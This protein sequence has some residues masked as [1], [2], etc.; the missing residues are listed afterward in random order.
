M[1]TK[2]ERVKYCMTCTNRKFSHH[3]GV[4][5]GL[6]NQV[7]TFSEECTDY[8]PDEKQLKLRKLRKREALDNA[9]K[10]LRNVRIAIFVIASLTIFYGFYEAFFMAGANVIFGVIDWFMG[11]VFI[12]LGIWSYSK[13]FLSFVIA[14]SI[15]VLI[16]VLFFIVEPVSIFKGIILKGVIIYT[17]IV[18]IQQ[19][20]KEKESL[21]PVDESLLD[22]S[23]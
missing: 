19:A 18:G 2:E 4:I 10:K 13:P 11:A 8:S 1:A 6:T 20:K 17:F 16:Q 21:K 5:C 3:E 23:F 7:A 9:R 15:Y 12:G 14:F 22:N